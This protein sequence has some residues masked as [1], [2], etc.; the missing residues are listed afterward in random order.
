MAGW[1][2]AGVFRDWSALIALLASLGLVAWLAAAPDLR[3]ILWLART[4]LALGLAAALALAL[5]E[6]TRFLLAGT[7]N[8][9]GAAWFLL[10]LLLTG[11]G[12][13]FWTR[14]SLNLA[15]QAR[16]PEMLRLRHGFWFAAVPRAA[17]LLP[18]AAAAVCL[19]AA[20]PLF[21]EGQRGLRWVLLLGIG[22]V[23]FALV[24]LAWGRRR[25]IRRRRGTLAEGT[26]RL[27]LLLADEDLPDP[28]PPRPAG[29]HPW[30]ATALACLPFR[31]RLL[32]PLLL[33]FLLGIVSVQAGWA[34]PSAWAQAVGA[35]PTA[36]FGLAALLTLL[37][38]SIG[39]LGV[40]LHWP[41]LFFLALL[42]IGAAG[43]TVN[44]LVRTEA[45]LP[46]R[47]TLEKAAARWLLSCA[48]GEGPIRAM[49]VAN[50]GGASRAALWTAATLTALEPREP[51]EPGIE[52]QGPDIEPRRHLFALAGTSGGALGAAAY[53]ASLE[54]AGEHCAP[55]SGARPAA[56]RLKRLREGLSSDFL[57]PALAGL[58]LG[59]GVWRVFGPVSALAGWLGLWPEDRTVRLEHAWEAAFAF[60]GV[61]PMAG[62]LAAGTFDKDGTPRLPLLLT[63]GT[64]VETGQP[65]LTAPVE[66]G[67]LAAEA[68]D[69]LGV[70]RADVAF[71]T[72]A[73]NSA[74][75]PYVT[76]P[77]LLRP[78]QAVPRPACPPARPKD[79]TATPRRP[80][81]GQIVDGG[82]ADNAS[83]VAARGAAEALVAAYGELVAAGRLPK[84]RPLHV[85]V[86]QVVSNP[87][88]DP[89]SIPRCGAT[90]APDG[91][92]FHAA[93]PLDFLLSPIGTLVSVQGQS[94]IAGATALQ[95]RYCGTP[96]GEATAGGG[97]VFRHFHAFAMG[98]DAEGIEAPLSWVL[99]PGVRARITQPDFDGFPTARNP[100]ELRRLGQ[101]WAAAGG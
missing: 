97:R 24:A 49:V 86:V 46:P 42:V 66:L 57:A 59:D 1:N 89:A 26:G 87:R 33:A 37:A 92:G 84:E 74:R 61:S 99:T 100:A 38:P 101:E 65:A 63:T 14:W 16:E 85:F 53:V 78:R 40:G 25:L 90:P 34:W 52:L 15:W 7:G 77:G 41:A 70:L 8:L 79:A 72:A 9:W 28:P 64:H 17:A 62:H 54:K 76:S 43:A 5:P 69:L 12:S 48:G 96:E 91:T 30:L 51:R 18:V 75:F 98:P 22:A 45:E 23:G 93:S 81:C 2:V 88:L 20:W 19:V 29:L 32:V 95:R 10:A 44:T 39:L 3:R 80:D 67:S 56:E 71:S 94:T 36:L 27:R 73:G 11:T 21:G 13:W 35:A 58:L 82:Y 31:W 60:G 50:A 83:A 6:Q 4:P 68:I 55:A 47:P